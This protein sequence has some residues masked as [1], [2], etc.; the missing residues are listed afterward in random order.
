MRT[1]PARKSHGSFV[2]ARKQRLADISLMRARQ[3][4]QTTI[5]ALLQPAFSDFTPATILI[6]AICIGQ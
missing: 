5:V 3:A 2:V 4:D 1:P 6:G